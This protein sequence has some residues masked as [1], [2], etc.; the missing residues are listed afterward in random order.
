VLVVSRGVGTLSG[1]PVSKGDT[2]V[3]PFSA[4]LLM[5]EGDVDAV[6]CRPPA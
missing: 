6:R 3:I 1:H 5:L 2:W 4:G